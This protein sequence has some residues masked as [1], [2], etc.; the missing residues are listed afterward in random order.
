MDTEYIILEEVS[1]ID[2]T[3]NRMSI[4]SFGH[5]STSE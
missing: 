5:D 3:R 4:S 1:V 2:F